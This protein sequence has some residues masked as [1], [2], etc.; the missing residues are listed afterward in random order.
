[1]SILLV[2]ASYQEISLEELEVIEK[3]S[4]EIRSAL[5]SDEASAHGIEGC[6][7]VSTCN[8]FEV[9]VDTQ[10]EE[11][12][13]EYI[14][15]RVRDLSGIQ[16][17]R[18]RVRVGTEAV[19]HLFRVSAGLE[20]MIVGEV[21]ISGQVKRSLSESQSLGQ[22][23]RTTEALFQRASEV[24][25]KVT[26]ETGLGAAGRS[27]ITG[28]LDIVKDHGFDL[29]MR[30]VLVIGTGAYA[31]VVISALERE[32]VGEIFTY[33]NSGRAEEF[34]ESHGTTPVING[35]LLGALEVCEMIVACSGTHETIISTEQI[36]ATNKEFLP[37][38]DLSLA[39]DVEKTAKSLPNVI[40]VDLE[41]IHRRAPAEHHQTIVQAGELVDS[42]VSKFEQDLEARRNDPL[43]RLLREHVEKI[44]DE[45]VARI[46]QKN[47]D[48]YANQVARSLHSVTKTIF[49]KPTIAARNSSMSEESNEYQQAIKVLFGLKF[50]PDDA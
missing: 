36:R 23:S 4:H 44:V 48:E 18:L 32:N 2:G 3:K 14:I 25:K 33:S 27:L 49:H 17:T 20:S 1:M 22:T 50:G 37:I 38:I 8:R 39:H 42:L 24:A 21:E 13:S 10:R 34:S 43:V 12:S 5:F 35:G 31:R 29:R 41:E 16:I 47:G 15:G 7:I 30:K 11:E 26:S 19:K 28:G 6:V 45:E 40:V 46:R 9:Y